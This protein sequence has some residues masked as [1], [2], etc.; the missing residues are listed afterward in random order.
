LRTPVHD[1]R[2]LE[3]AGMRFIEASDGE[4]AV[5]LAISEQPELILMEFEFTEA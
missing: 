3:M 2:L 4:Q 1:A 5:A